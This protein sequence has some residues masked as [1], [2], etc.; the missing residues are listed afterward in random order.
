MGRRCREGPSPPENTEGVDETSGLFDAL[1][2]LSV[3][4]G[5]RSILH[6][7]VT[8]TEPHDVKC[9]VRRGLLLLT[10]RLLCLLSLSLLRH[11][12]ALL[13]TMMWRCRNSAA[14]N[15]RAL[16]SELHQHDGKNTDST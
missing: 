3:S 11:F 6:Q 13:A 10:R 12:A 2:R 9:K 5:L 15:R 14:A 8:L 4:A 1:C 16:T 7:H